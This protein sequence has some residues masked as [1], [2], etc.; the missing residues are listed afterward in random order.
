MVN[1]PKHY[2]S[3]KTGIEVI[4]VTRYLT[5]SLSNAW[6]YCCRYLLKDTP[7][8]DLEKACFYLRDFCNHPAI[9]AYT[10]TDEQCKRL[11]KKMSKFIEVEDIAE[12]RAV[13]IF[14]KNMVNICY[15]G[16]KDAEILANEI[17]ADE[18]INNLKYYADALGE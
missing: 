3:S 13:M 6:K 15:N 1:H 11:L 7:K 18:V 5:G 8:Q 16:D 9:N 14:I 4:E 2:T 17:G 10:C 12:I